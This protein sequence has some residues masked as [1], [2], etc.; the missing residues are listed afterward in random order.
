MQMNATTET[1]VTTRIFPS[2]HIQTYITPPIILVDI[3]H[4]SPDGLRYPSSQN[5]NKITYI[6]MGRDSSVGIA[7]R[8]RTGRSG[9]RIPV[10]V[11]IFHTRPDRHST[12]I[13]PP[14]QWV[15]GL[16]RG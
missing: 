15:P 9:D 4:T 5:I 12:P 8:V 1:R 13:H 14:V 6:F 10:G 2:T 11:E 3:F 7:T 16:S